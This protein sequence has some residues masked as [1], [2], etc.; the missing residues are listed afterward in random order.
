[1]RASPRRCPPLPVQ[2]ADFATW[3]RRWVQ[4]EG[5]QAQLEALKSR[6]QGV[7]ALEL[8]AD[9]GRPMARTLRGASHFF[10]LP[11]ELVHALEKVGRD[12]GATLFM[13][14]L[15]AYETLLARYSGQEDFAIGSPIAHRTRAELEPLIGF[16]VNTLVL[17]TRLEGDP[18]FAELV[19]RV[20]ESALAAYVHQDVP[21]DRLVEAL[22]GERSEGRAPLFNV[23][24]ALQNAPMQPPSLPGVQVDLMRSVTDTARFDLSLSLMERGGALEGALE[25]SLDLFSQADRR[26]GCRGTSSSSWEAVVRDANV[27]GQPPAR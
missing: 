8:P 14:L 15:A 21:F 13:V 3:Q 26:R 17:R 22:G 6:L 4:A 12:Q 16:F 1:M 20:R 10:T 2:Y 9:S 5:I 24:F 25:Y 19:D 23:M 18:T 7:P 11:E 27:R